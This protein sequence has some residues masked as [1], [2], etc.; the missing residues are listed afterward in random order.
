MGFTGGCCMCELTSVFH[1]LS[2]SPW[3]THTHTMKACLTALQLGLLWQLFCA[4]QKP[5]VG[6]H[7]CLLSTG[8]QMPVRA[9]RALIKSLR[10]S[11]T[12]FG[13]YNNHID[14]CYIL[15]PSGSESKESEKEAKSFGARREG[16][17]GR[18]GE[19]LE[20]IY[21]LPLRSFGHYSSSVSFLS[22]K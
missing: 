11:E 16:E 4:C 10:L 18:E 12:D 21:S 14:H 13:F 5:C 15:W 22:N 17:G 2:K 7:C 9:R 1:R 19:N 3:H 8:T 20:Y 6:A